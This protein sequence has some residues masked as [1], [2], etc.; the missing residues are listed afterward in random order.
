MKDD[1][2]LNLIIYL[3]NIGTII[4]NVKLNSYLKGLIEKTIINGMFIKFIS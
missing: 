1:T 2:N 3:T 4:R